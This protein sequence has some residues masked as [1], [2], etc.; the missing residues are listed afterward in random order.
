MGE[1]ELFVWVNKLF[2]LHQPTD[3]TQR[4]RVSAIVFIDFSRIHIQVWILLKIPS[5]INS[6]DYYKQHRIYKT[7]FIELCSEAPSYLPVYNSTPP[8]VYKSRQKISFSYFWVR[9]F[10]KNLSF[11]SELSLMYAMVT[12][13]KIVVKFS[14]S[15]FDPCRS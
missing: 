12:Q 11:I 9:I 1:G 4:K 10:Q 7:C 15:V 3:L 5:D 2:T 13:K 6:S 8:P 14:I